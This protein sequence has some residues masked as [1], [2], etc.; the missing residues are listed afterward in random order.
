MVYV[1]RMDDIDRGLLTQYRREITATIVVHRTELEAH[2]P[3]LI[4]VIFSVYSGFKTWQHI[5]DY[6]GVADV[7]YLLTLRRSDY[8]LASYYIKNIFCD[9]LDSLHILADEIQHADWQLL[10]VP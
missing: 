2:L 8:L 1:L 5:C 10:M 3:F 9:N 7:W 4:L 6:S